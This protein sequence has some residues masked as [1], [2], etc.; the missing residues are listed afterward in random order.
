MLYQTSDV[1]ILYFKDGTLIAI[2]LEHLL[3]VLHTHNLC[4]LGGH[5]TKNFIVPKLQGFHVSLKNLSPF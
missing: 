4:M 1:L 3:A 2:K 5:N